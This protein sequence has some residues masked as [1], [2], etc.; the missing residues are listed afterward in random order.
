MSA[1][2]ARRR[3][4]GDTNDRSDGRAPT[5]G[6]ELRRLS[7]AESGAEMYT[8]MEEL[9]PLCRSLTGDGVR[10]TLRRIGARIPVDVHEVPTGT[11]AFDWQVPKEWNIRDAYIKDEA[12]ETVLSF[13]DSN[14]HVVGYSVPVRERPPLA[15]LKEHLF[16]LPEHP[17]WI[18]YR[19]SYYSETWGFCLTHRQLTQLRDGIYEV[20]I[21]SRLTDGH[22]TYG[23]CCIPGRSEDEVVIFTHT[24]HPSLCNDNLSGIALATRLAQALHGLSLRY[25]YRFVFAPATIGSI[26]WLSQNEARLA[27]V[28]HGLVVANAGDPG[29]LTYKRSR[30]GRAEIDCAVTHVLQHSSQ[31]HAVLEFSPWGY[32]ERQFGSPGINLP[33]GRLTRSPEGTFPEY[34]T[35]A[36]NLQFVRHECLSESLA[37]VLRVFAVL[38]GNARYVN[39]SP[40]GEPQLGRRGLYRKMGGYQDVPRQQLAL[41]WA[42]SFST[43]DLSLLDIAEKSG[44]DFES[45]RSAASD[46]EGNGLL[47]PREESA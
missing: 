12:G 24:C 39:L 28:K 9:Y 17:D 46:L 38:E 5:L 29:K 35:S 1:P 43:G 16:S 15:E 14:L 33:V 27:R 30:H 34:H 22:L 23:E 4:V 13:R 37:T 45:I 41:L 21:D 2:T 18:P 44:L 32:D 11:Q 40:K 26:T 42:L 31:P 20:V 19:T 10:E 47:A 7:L 25:T 8:L 6:E 3:V 36:D